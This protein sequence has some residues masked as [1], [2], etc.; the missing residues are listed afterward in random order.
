MPHVAALLIQTP[1]LPEP[2]DAAPGSSPP[3]NVVENIPLYL[4]SS[5][6]I[7]V[8]R[9]PELADICQLERRLREPQASDALAG[10]QRQRRIIQGLW[11]FKQLNAAGTGNRP[12]TKMVT[13]YKRFDSKCKRAI[14]EYRTAWNALR[15]LDPS[16]PWTTH[17]KE[18]KNEDIRGP[19]KDANDP[20]PSNSRYEPS[21]IWLVPRATQSS[22]TDYTEEFN[23]SMR[24]EWAKS[25]A[26]MMRWKEEELLIQEEMRRVLAYLASRAEWW[27]ERSSLRTN[28]E[29][30]ILSGVSGYAYKQADVC[31]RIAERCAYYWL[32]RLKA[33]GITPSWA[34]DFKSPPDASKSRRPEPRQS[35][36]VRNGSVTDH[37]D[38]GSEESDSEA[39]EG[40]ND[41]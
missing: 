34:A 28:G 37:D 35:S 8:R 9:L 29:P 27:R 1:T 20:S 38:S 33:H 7:H 30:S 23:N 15:T 18:L 25:R 31:T 21:W 36:N 26:R 4:P 2:T 40:E 13:L 39:S 5:L 22:S 17:L 3:E 11:Q 14:Q 24:V 19:G 6:P 32:P 10:I 16:G 12:N 41:L